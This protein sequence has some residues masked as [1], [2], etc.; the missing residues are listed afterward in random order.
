MTRPL[1]LD[2]G[3]K[4]AGGPGGNRGAD[5]P[6]A[7]TSQPAPRKI[8]PAMEWPWA[9]SGPGRKSGP[10]GANVAAESAPLRRSVDVPTEANAL[11]RSF[12]SISWTASFALL[13]L[14][15]A[16]RAQATSTPLVLTVEGTL[17]QQG[18]SL[19]WPPDPTQRLLL[20][21]RVRTSVNAS[22]T[23]AGAAP[24]LVQYFNAAS[25]Q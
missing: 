10:R 19:P 1:G 25:G 16:A 13:V 14:V 24:E 12:C 2:T 22:S 21:V 23:A 8:Q 5:V 7:S 9:R 11:M 6:L 18:S 3:M 4:D 20:D 15:S 17:A